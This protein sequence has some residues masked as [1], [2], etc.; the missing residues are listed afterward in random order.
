MRGDRH[1]AACPE[2]RCPRRP[3][4]YRATERGDGAWQQAVTDEYPDLAGIEPFEHE[5]V[6]AVKECR[7]KPAEQAPPDEPADRDRAHREEEHWDD[8]RSR[9]SEHP[10][11]GVGDDREGQPIV[12]VG[13]EPEHGGRYHLRVGA[14]NPVEQQEPAMEERKAGGDTDHDAERRQR[15]V[16]PL[17]EVT[18]RAP[19]VFAARAAP[20]GP[21]LGPQR[22]VIRSF[23]PLGA[24]IPGFQRCRHLVASVRRVE[25]GSSRG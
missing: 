11:D 16:G 13:G 20:P 21:I 18:V 9:C 8:P 15:H 2:S 14:A 19:R 1:Q 17:E 23:S 7:G 12:Q 10:H 6:H 22:P 4:L 25:R 3:A 5:R 24:G